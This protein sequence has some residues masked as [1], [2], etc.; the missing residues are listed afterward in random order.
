MFKCFSLNVWSHSERTN[1]SENAF[2][3]KTKRTKTK[4]TISE[5]HQAIKLH[6]KEQ[7]KTKQ[8]M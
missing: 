8:R 1:I 3:I 4:C 7:N 6:V 2:D 5:E